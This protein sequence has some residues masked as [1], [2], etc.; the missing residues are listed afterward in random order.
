MKNNK[1]L[2]NC[3]KVLKVSSL[4]REQIDAA[5][6]EEAPNDSPFIYHPLAHCGTRS[7]SRRRL[8]LKVFE[9]PRATHTHTVT[10]SIKAAGGNL[11][12]AGAERQRPQN[13]RSEKFST[14]AVTQSESFPLLFKETQLE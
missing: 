3:F 11:R 12:F 7:F 5:F 4:F 14:D 1:N 13:K 8:I 10:A 9:G 6:E 2:L